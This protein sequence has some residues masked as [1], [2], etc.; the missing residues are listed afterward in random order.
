[1]L[2]IRR[3]DVAY[4]AGETIVLSVDRASYDKIRTETIQSDAEKKINFLI[5]YVPRLRMSPRNIIEELDLLFVK[6]CYTRGYKILKEGEFNENVYFIRSGICKMMYSLIGPMKKVK[7][8]LSPEEQEKYKY[9]TLCNVSVGQSFGEDSGLNGNK[10]QETVQAESEVVEAYKISKSMLLQYFGGSSSE[11]L[12]SIRANIQTKKNWNQLKITQ[13]S[14]MKKEDLMN[15]NLLVDNDIYKE[16]NPTKTLPGEVP[17]LKMT[18]TYGKPSKETVLKLTKEE[19][20]KAKEAVLPPPPKPEMRPRARNDFMVGKAPDEEY[21][22]NTLRGFGTMRL[23]AS[24]RMKNITSQQMRGLVALRSIAQDVRSGTKRQDNAGGF[25]KS[26]LKKF[27]DSVTMA[28]PAIAAKAKANPS[29]DSGLNMFKKMRDFD[30]GNLKAK[31][32]Q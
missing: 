12:Y 15:A 7:E 17:Y 28:D 16:L 6:E 22:D 1:M 24:D 3:Q 31:L 18:Q 10:V 21:K 29:G 13:Y 19:E 26:S 4:A 23:V 9:I 14:S 27:Q 30:S 5:R 25:D 32:G 8:Q 2:V 11:I 20:A